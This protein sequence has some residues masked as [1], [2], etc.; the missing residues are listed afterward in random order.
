MQKWKRVSIKLLEK[1]VPDDKQ[2]TTKVTSFSRYVEINHHAI[3]V[4]CTSVLG[5]CGE[6]KRIGEGERLL[7][8]HSQQ[9]FLQMAQP[10]IIVK[11]SY[12]RLLFRC[13][14]YEYWKAL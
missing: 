6:S 4:I 7:I 1:Q 8:R 13:R 14:A 9:R 11:H 5:K 10:R 3:E 2:H 12:D